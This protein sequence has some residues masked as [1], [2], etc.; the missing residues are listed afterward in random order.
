MNRRPEY[1][2]SASAIL[3]LVC[4]PKIDDGLL[5]GVDLSLAVPAHG[6]E[7]DQV[8]EHLAKTSTAQQ[9]VV[10]WVAERLDAFM[11]MGRKAARP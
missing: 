9:I 11:L 4:N 2:A 3:H 1:R 10:V 5:K 7:P 6:L 8:G